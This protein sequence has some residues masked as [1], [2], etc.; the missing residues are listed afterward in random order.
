MPGPGPRFGMRMGEKPKLNMNAL[1]KLF[2]YMNRYIVGLIFSIVLAIGS[3]ITTIIGPDKIKNL[4]NE[5]VSSMIT[6]IDMKKVMNIALGILA[7]YLMSSIFNYIQH[8]IMVT[9]TQKTSKRF[10]SDIDKKLYRLPLAYFD[11]NTKGDILSKVTNDVDTISQTLSSSI[12]NLF[13]SVV[14]FFGI[15]IMMFITNWVLAIVTII[16]SILGMIFVPMIVKGSQKYFVNNQVLLGKMNGQIEEVFT[17]HNIVRAYNGAALEK[18]VFNE[19]N[20]ALKESNWKSQFISGLM[21]PIMIFVGN[22]TYLL[23]FVVGALLY[24]KG[25]TLVTIG[26]L[27]SFVIYAKL[28]SNPLQTFAQSLTNLQQASAAASR[29]FSVLDEKEMP[30]EKHLTGKIEKVLGNIEFQNVRFGYFPDKE[31]IH[32]F[33]ASIKSGQKVAI[34]GP[35]G[36]GKTTIVNLLMKFYDIDSGDII[37]DGVSIRDMKRET[38]HDLFDMILQDTWLFKGTLRENL[39][40]NKKNVP[41]AVL[42]KVCETV[43]LKHFVNGLPNGYDTFIDESSQLSEGQKQQITIAR[44]MIKDAPLLIL[45][46]A[47]S[48]VDTRTELIIQKAMDELTKGRTSFVIAHRLSTI[49]NADLILVIKDGDIIEQGTH[50]M[51]LAKNGFYAELYNSQFQ[52]I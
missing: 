24:L 32:G 42:D 2:K 49:R 40:F 48:N 8:F 13:S 33:T 27:T 35:T 36:A 39:I 45:D 26:T 37:I 25:Y 6:G 19:T 3:A 9:I 41:D 10:R 11:Q 38:V 46:E 51:L 1:K 23:I 28:F 16:S 7:L 43:G 30:N 15:L 50:E 4:T 14:L 12:A 44:A 47:T 21:H 17:N 31:I 20:S 34:V 52:N 22:I 18:K 5:I 29:V